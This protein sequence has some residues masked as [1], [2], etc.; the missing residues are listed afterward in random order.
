MS[1]MKTTMI[2]LA[3]YMLPDT[4]GSEACDFL[5][6]EACG[7]DQSELR[8]VFGNVAYVGMGPTRS[9]RLFSE[10]EVKTLLD[11]YNKIPMEKASV[12]RPLLANMTRL[13]ADEAGQLDLP[14][15]L[16]AYA[17]LRE[18]P[19]VLAEADDGGLFLCAPEYLEELEELL[20]RRG[21]SAL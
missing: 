17:Q 21:K 3:R 19:A 20:R 12:L 5:G 7:A 10:P 1:G 14:E 8:E 9:L 4:D 15:R 2:Q 18:G 16:C 11:H 6:C 13:K